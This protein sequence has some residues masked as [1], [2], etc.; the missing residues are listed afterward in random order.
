MSGHYR[1]GGISSGVAI[2]RGSTVYIN[3]TDHLPH[4]LIFVI[5]I[6]REPLFLMFSIMTTH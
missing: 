6:I 1:E 2:K 4:F 5:P 3:I